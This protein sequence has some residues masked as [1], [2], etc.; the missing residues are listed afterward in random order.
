MLTDTSLSSYLP[1]PW[2]CALADMFVRLTGFGNAAGLMVNRGLFGMGGLANAR[3]TREDVEK[4]TG[5]PLPRQTSSDAAS[6]SAPGAGEGSSSPVTLQEA[7]GT[8]DDEEEA[9]AERLMRQLEDM[10]RRGLVKLVRKS[11]NL[12]NQNDEPSEDDS[13]DHRGKHSH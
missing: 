11:D 8:D 12:D 1:I 6:T 7:L 13:H 10:E 4:M 9:K 2:V 3:T 5:K